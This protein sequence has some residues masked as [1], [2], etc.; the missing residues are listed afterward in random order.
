MEIAARRRLW[1]MIAAP[2]LALVLL[3]AYVVYVQVGSGAPA[4]HLGSL[5]PAPA[6][7]LTKLNVGDL[8]LAASAAKSIHLEYDTVTGPPGA[9]HTN[10]SIVKSFA[11]DV[12]SPASVVV[13]GG[14]GT[15][16][17]KVAEITITKVTDK[18]SLPLFSKMLKGTHVP[19]AI[20]YFTNATAAGV[21]F[22][23]LEFDLANPTLTD[24]AMSSGGD[25]PTES[26]SLHFTAV[27]MKA[28]IAGAPAQTL[29]YNV[30]TNTTT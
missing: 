28:H 4:R 20:I 6:P 15:T 21:A 7:A 12:S 23:D 11:W 14:G 13:G 17:P 26:L 1:R 2:L 27:T 22:D 19:G 24:F 9:V 10:H 30:A 8:L 5:A 16:K 18:Y 25:T 3:V 29:T